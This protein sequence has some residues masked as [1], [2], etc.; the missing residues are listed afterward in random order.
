M[1]STV[2]PE[3][4]CPQCGKSTLPLPVPHLSAECKQCSRTV[5]FVRSGEN[6]EGICIEAGERFS[7]PVGWLNLS[8]E[9]G[10]QGKL[11]R[12]GLSFLL[13]QFFVG[14]TPV[15]KDITEFVVELEEDF[16]S[17][18]KRTEAAEGLDLS[19]EDGATELVA[20]LEKDKQSRDW[21]IVAAAIFCGGIKHAIEEDNAQRAAW[22]GYMMGTW[23]G[24]SIVSEPVF[25]ET[26]WR[27]YLANEVV[28]EAAAAAGNRSPAE[29]EAL[30]KLEP[31][32]QQL[33]ETTLHALVESGIPIGPKINITHLPE[34]L[35]R[36]LAK[37]EI[38]SRERERQDARQAEKDK[39]EEERWR[40]KDR[41]EEIEVRIKWAAIGAT[42][43]G[44]IATLVVK[45]A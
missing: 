26:L 19:T 8:L 3:K 44:A 43:V 35:L 25:E 5:H 17:Y 13:N 38:A 1:T 23:R 42:V 21:Y 40:K 31:L 12:S 37:H 22:A 14:K 32:F 16:D 11:Y 10:P 39:V 27:G 18:I 20:R 30:K 29:L 6:G 45:F 4:F 36:A 33:D 2:L 34:P 7:I 24:L 9:P 41:R 15:E 28:F